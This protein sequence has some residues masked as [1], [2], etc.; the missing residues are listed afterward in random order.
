MLRGPFII[1]RMSWF[2]LRSEWVYEMRKWRWMKDFRGAFAP[3]NRPKRKKG[4]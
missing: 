1:P 4:R 2:K 3:Y